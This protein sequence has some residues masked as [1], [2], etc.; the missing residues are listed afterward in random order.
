MANRRS[1]LT[2]HQKA[3]PGTALC[4]G[5][6]S[7]SPSGNITPQM[8]SCLHALRVSPCIYVCMAHTN[9]SLHISKL[10]QLEL[11]ASSRR[12]WKNLLLSKYTEPKATL[13]TAV[14]SSLCH[15]QN[16]SL[17]HETTAASYLGGQQCSICG[18]HNLGKHLRKNTPMTSSFKLTKAEFFSLV[19]QSGLKLAGP[20]A[21]ERASKARQG[22]SS[23]C[24]LLLHS[25]SCSFSSFFISFPFPWSNGLS[26]SQVICV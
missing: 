1:L 18:L 19:V 22:Q 10:L 11:S 9:R 14:S 2:F 23:G 6:R 26:G 4:S 25:P 17:F 12:R 7:V 13:S 24:L 5:L 20:R 15:R 21:R 8:Y 3:V 16:F